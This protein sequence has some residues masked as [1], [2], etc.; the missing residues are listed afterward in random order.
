MEKSAEPR[1]EDD[2]DENE[3]D[4]NI[5]KELLRNCFGVDSGKT[6]RQQQNLYNTNIYISWAI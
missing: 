4:I 3:N 2:K 6:A 1:E 5:L